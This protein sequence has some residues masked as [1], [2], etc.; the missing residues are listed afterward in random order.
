[1]EKNIDPFLY[2]VHELDIHGYDRLGAEAMIKNF[3]DNEVRIGSKK[4]SI[5]HGKGTGI[6]KKTTHEYL[7]KDKRVLNY[8]LNIFNE[9]QTI[10]TLK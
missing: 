9:G 6:L 4:I 1:M 8:K 10:V 2:N 7:K 5:V 3:I